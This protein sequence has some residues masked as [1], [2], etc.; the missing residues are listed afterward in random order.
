[1]LKM[2]M[3]TPRER[4]KNRRRLQG[5]LVGFLICPFTPL[6]DCDFKTQAFM[7]IK[8]WSI[9]LWRLLVDFLNMSLR[10]QMKKI[11]C[12]Y[13]AVNSDLFLYSCIEFECLHFSR[14]SPTS[15]LVMKLMKLIVISYQSW[16][17]SI[18]GALLQMRTYMTTSWA[19]S[20][21]TFTLYSAFHR[22]GRN[23]EIELWS[24]LPLFQDALLT[25][26]ADGPRMP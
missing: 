6:K 22:W 8:V 15:L 26:S 13:R 21:R 1:M 23:F 19:G 12:T 25:G 7:C 20:D 4:W 10:T 5:K 18:P 16:K 17:K 14:R 3:E 24:F 9:L 11:L 2:L